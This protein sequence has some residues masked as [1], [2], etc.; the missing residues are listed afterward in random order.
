MPFSTPSSTPRGLEYVSQA[1]GRSNDSTHSSVTLTIPIP[2]SIKER[3][4]SAIDGALRKNKETSV[5]AQT[6]AN[7]RF[8]L[9]PLPL[10]IILIWKPYNNEHN[11]I[12]IDFH[13]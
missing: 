13:K 3:I 2:G 11:S 6:M 1:S 8:K 9:Y 4:P 12:I 5:T 7:G 10:F